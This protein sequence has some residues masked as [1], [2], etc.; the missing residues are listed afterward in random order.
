MW[1][2]N[3]ERFFYSVCAVW[4]GAHLISSTS[5]ILYIQWYIFNAVFAAATAFCR[6]FSC[7]FFSNRFLFSHFNQIFEL[8]R[9]WRTDII[10]SN[11][12]IIKSKMNIFYA[13]THFSC[14]H[15]NSYA[16][17]TQIPLVIVFHT[18]LICMET[19]CTRN[20]I[21]TIYIL[22]LKCLYYNQ[23]I[24]FSNVSLS[25]FLFSFSGGDIQL[26]QMT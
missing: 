1:E 5:S 6:C 7:C 3:G 8:F 17:N 4:A 15:W 2:R 9:H 21:C 14:F 23:L 13:L 19:L 24:F 22:S 18:R 12:I 20:S 10:D 16:Y 25:F 26:H 11:F